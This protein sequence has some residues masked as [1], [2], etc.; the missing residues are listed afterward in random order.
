MRRKPGKLLQI[1]TSILEAG[2]DLRIRGMPD[3]YG[4]QIAKEIADKETRR[5]LTA[6]GT[7][8]R[9]L[10]RMEGAGLLISSWEDPKLA[11]EARRPLRR[12]YQ[13]TAMGQ[14]AL[15]DAGRVRP[16]PGM[17]V[18]GGLAP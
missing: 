18:E 3:F 6:Y 15:A 9:A 1:E 2:I 16:E 10:N 11:A 7:L 17:I 12:L 13:V 5:R 4:F 8:Y 14:R